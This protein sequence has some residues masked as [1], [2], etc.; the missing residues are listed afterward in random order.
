MLE[1]TQKGPRAFVSKYM[2]TQHD[3]A[4]PWLLFLQGKDND[5]GDESSN[6]HNPTR[7]RPAQ[8]NANLGFLTFDINKGAIGGAP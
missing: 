3:E 4:H 8:S 6:L 2:A 7:A 1:A 5:A